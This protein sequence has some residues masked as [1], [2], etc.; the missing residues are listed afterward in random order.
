MRRSGHVHFNLMIIAPFSCISESELATCLIPGHERTVRIKDTAEIQIQ[1]DNILRC[2]ARR[3][4]RT[5]S[6]AWLDALFVNALKHRDMGA[7]K[8]LCIRRY[9]R[10]TVTRARP[11]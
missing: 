6:M 7:Q 8:V 1:K 4:Q 9:L 3:E 2:E 11:K 10:A 5:A